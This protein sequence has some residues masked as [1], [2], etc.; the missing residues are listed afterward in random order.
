MKT[1]FILASTIAFFAFSA[2]AVPVPGSHMSA[3]G[4]NNEGDTS[5]LL[6]NV[7]KDGVL[8]TN[9]KQSKTIQCGKGKGGSQSVGGSNNEGSTKGLLNN[10]L[11][12]GIL[13]TNVQ[14]SEVIQC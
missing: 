11:K 7:L 13:N 4:N 14:S 8:N 1:S 2:A 9:V 5:G 3:G 6:N 10:L 12:G